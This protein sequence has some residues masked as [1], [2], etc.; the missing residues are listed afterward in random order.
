[1][2]LPHPLRRGIPRTYSR[3]G[4]RDVL[5][6]GE[7]RGGG[8]RGGVHGGYPPSSYGAR[9]FQCITGGGG[10]PPTS[11]TVFPPGAPMGGG[12]GQRPRVKAFFRKW[13][14]GRDVRCDGG[15]AFGAQPYVYCPFNPLK[16]QATGSTHHQSLPDGTSLMV[17]CPEVPFPR[18][19]H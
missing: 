8:S 5:E 6:G 14:S 9:P 11:P 13:S 1:M 18:S 7:G 16:Y 12:W 15:W 3:G 2:S 19:P 4:G 10:V 17:A